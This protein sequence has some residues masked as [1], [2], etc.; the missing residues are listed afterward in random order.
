MV[1]CLKAIR[2]GSSLLTPRWDWISNQRDLPCWTGG[3]RDWAILAQDGVMKVALIASSFSIYCSEGICGVRSH[4]YMQQNVC[5]CVHSWEFL[6]IW[7]SMHTGKLCVWACESY[8]WPSAPAVIPSERSYWA[9][10]LL[11][12]VPLILKLHMKPDNKP[13]PLIYLPKTAAPG[14]RCQ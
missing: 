10:V 9:P 1:G 12:Y 7:P 13:H 4:I 6:S 8:A 5:V 11:H 2:H 3:V 14:S